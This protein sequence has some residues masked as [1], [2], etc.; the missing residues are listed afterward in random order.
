[1]S[2]PYDR[3]TH[4]TFPHARWQALAL[5]AALVVA[6]GVALGALLPPM[7]MAADKAYNPKPSEDQLIRAGYR[8]AGE[9][10]EDKF[11]E[12]PGDET[13]IRVFKKGQETLGL[14][15]LPSGQIYGYAVKVGNQPLTAYI[16]E[17]NTGYCQKDYGDGESFSIDFASYRTE[18]GYDSGRRR[19]SR[20]KQ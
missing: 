19:S 10:F 6:L 7:A 15:I 4:R 9:K 16:D 11:P 3:S 1:M 17:Y 14:Y 18:P 2:A 12:I 13:N 8:F 20:K 5:G